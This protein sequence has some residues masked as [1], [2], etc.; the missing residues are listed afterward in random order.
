VVVLDR[1]NSVLSLPRG[2][3]LVR[4]FGREAMLAPK[5]SAGYRLAGVVAKRWRLVTWRSAG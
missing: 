3:Q 2:D 4:S 1:M 5:S